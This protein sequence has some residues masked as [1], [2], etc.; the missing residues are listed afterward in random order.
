M[1]AR[2]RALQVAIVATGIAFLSLQI[3]ICV[4]PS[5][6]RW[7]PLHRCDEQ[8]IVGVYATLGVFLILAARDPAQHKS[9]IAFTIWS[10]AVHATIMLVQSFTAPVHHA[11]LVGDVP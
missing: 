9:L 7:T 4:W 10:S 3:L 5:A 2:L 1:D 6:W 11:H 8:M